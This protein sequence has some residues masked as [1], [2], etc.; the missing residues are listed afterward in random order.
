MIQRPSKRCI[1]E[2]NL[3][4]PA[5]ETN[6]LALASAF[7]QTDCKNMTLKKQT[8]IGKLYTY[9][10]EQKRLHIYSGPRNPI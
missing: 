8:C 9:S 7:N 5:M 2:A 6:A 10:R 4:N 3:A 1:P